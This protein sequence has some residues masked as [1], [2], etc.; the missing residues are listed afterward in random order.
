[1][2]SFFMFIFLGHLFFLN[3]FQWVI[4]GPKV[5]HFGPRSVIFFFM[6]SKFSSTTCVRKTTRRPCQPQRQLNASR[7]RY[8]GWQ[9]SSPS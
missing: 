2:G 4:S 1:M 7:R 6:V 3:F 9:W 8:N 5:G